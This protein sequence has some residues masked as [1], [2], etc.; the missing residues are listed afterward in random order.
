MHRTIAIA[1]ALTLLPCAVASAADNPS[2]TRSAFDAIRWQMTRQDIETNLGK[3][4]AVDDYNLVL[5]ALGTRTGD[6]RIPY[7]WVEQGLWLKWQGKDQTIWVQF[8][9]PTV[10]H[11]TNGSYSVGPNTE[12]AL[13]LFITEIPPKPMPMGQIRNM[14]IS[15]K[16][17]LRRG[18]ISAVVHQWVHEVLR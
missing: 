6:K 18:D 1:L 16:S 7:R 5:H 14:Q 15:W 11:N 17:G 13:V 12:C 10:V 2:V 4:E 3:G 9:G 8:G